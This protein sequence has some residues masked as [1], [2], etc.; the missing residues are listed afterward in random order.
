M[1]MEE[2]PLLHHS[3]RNPIKPQCDKLTPRTIVTGDCL[4][5]S[6][7]ASTFI[8]ESLS[9]SWSSLQKSFLRGTS[10]WSLPSLEFFV[11]LSDIVLYLQLNITFQ[12]NISPKGSGNKNPP[13]PQSIKM[14]Q[15]N[16]NM[17]LICYFNRSVYLFIFILPIPML[18]SCAEIK[19]TQRPACVV[20]SQKG[21]EGTLKFTLD[22]SNIIG[23]DKP[24]IN[25][26]GKLGSMYIFNLMFS[27]TRSISIYVLLY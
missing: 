5:F 18:H 8:E 3:K 10:V 22:P 26:I 16:N 24:Y 7:E 27:I 6:T 15:Q 25:L 9:P 23:L 2:K 4:G 19:Q 11:C 1:L 17:I 14:R 12:L 13:P 20:R 21:S